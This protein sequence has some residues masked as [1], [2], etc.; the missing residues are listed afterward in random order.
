MLIRI[1]G[2]HNAREEKKDREQ[3]NRLTTIESVQQNT[4]KQI[5]RN[6]EDIFIIK[7]DVNSILELLTKG[8]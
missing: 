2:K 4:I 8:G 7:T 3:D 6:T 1:I 5:Q